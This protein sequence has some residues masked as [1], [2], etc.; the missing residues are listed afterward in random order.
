[1]AI[2]FQVCFPY[3]VSHAL[4]T[5]ILYGLYI[6]HVH[7]LYCMQCTNLSFRCVSCVCIWNSIFFKFLKKIYWWIKY[8][9]IVFSHI[10]FSFCITLSNSF[11][12]RIRTSNKILI[13][14]SVHN[15][16][17]WNYTCEM[18]VCNEIYNSKTPVCRTTG[19]PLQKAVF[20]LPYGRL[21]YKVLEKSTL[22]FSP[23]T[24]ITPA[25]ASL[26]SLH[27]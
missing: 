25:L 26:H 14:V 8:I 23:V 16:I 10:P 1:M 17:Y 9:V 20:H 21:Y 5:T 6:E 15:I 3:C 11:F 12:C 2:V 22:H 19:Y 7:V 27:R 18:N 13:A 24:I 4:F